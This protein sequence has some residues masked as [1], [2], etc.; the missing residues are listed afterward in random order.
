VQKT[1]NSTTYFFASIST[2]EYFRAPA[3]GQMSVHCPQ[4]YHSAFVSSR[5]AF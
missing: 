2:R 5:F 4:R 1:I 3:A